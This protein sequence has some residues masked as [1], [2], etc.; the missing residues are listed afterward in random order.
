MSRK[1]LSP[2]SLD[3]KLTSLRQQGKKIVFTNG[4]FDLIHLGHVRLLEKSK[5]LGNILIVGLNSDSSVK[6]LKGKDR[7]LC[8]EK[9]RAGVLAALEAVDYVVLFSEQT[10]YRLIQKIKPNILVKGGD[11]KP[12]DV[13][14]AD[15]VKKNKGKV[16]IFPTLKGRGTT[17]LIK[18]IT[19]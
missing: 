10:P 19:S 12:K 2:S 18:K 16:L 11:Y 3:K 8:P 13:V 15:I 17:K 4:C 14:G 7:P 9:D 6:R 5:K 1:I